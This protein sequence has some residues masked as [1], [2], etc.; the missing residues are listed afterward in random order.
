VLEFLLGILFAVLGTLFGIAAVVVNLSRG[1]DILRRV[2]LYFHP[3][4]LTAP[5]RFMLDNF[6]AR[7]LTIG[8]LT[9]GFGVLGLALIVAS[10]KA[11]YEAL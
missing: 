9:Y 3:S 10:Y 2:G 5:W 8:F 1:V 6:F 4:G 7:N 11:L